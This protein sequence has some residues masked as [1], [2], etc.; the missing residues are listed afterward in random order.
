[1]SYKVAPLYSESNSS[2]NE[3]TSFGS[4]H[5]DFSLQAAFYNFHIFLIQMF[6]SF[7]F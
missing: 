3:R 5:L 7:A 1:M 2:K 4:F 6:L